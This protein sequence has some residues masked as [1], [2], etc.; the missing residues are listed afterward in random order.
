[1]MK[2]FICSKRSKGKQPYIC[3]NCYTMF[4]GIFNIKGVNKETFEEHQKHCRNC[5]STNP[6]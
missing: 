5:Q 2:C 4:K 6:K 3:K 1:M